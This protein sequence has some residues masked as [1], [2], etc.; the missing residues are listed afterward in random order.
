MQSFSIADANTLVRGVLRCQELS[1]EVGSRWNA[2]DAKPCL[3]RVA[4][5]D[6]RVQIASRVTILERL[7]TMSI[8]LI[9][10][11]NHGYGGG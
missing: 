4:S 6:R 3:G 1:N 9:R 7:R 5:F 11:L 10:I 8:E 2:F